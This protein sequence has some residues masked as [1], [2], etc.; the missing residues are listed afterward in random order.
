[1]FLTWKR[2]TALS[3]AISEESGKG[4]LADTTTTVG[5]TDRV[6]MTSSLLGTTVVSIGE[7]ENTSKETPHF[8][9]E[10][11]RTYA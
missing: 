7:N 8:S 9:R 2:F 1:M 5:A 3:Y 6:H 4:Y 10:R 11:V